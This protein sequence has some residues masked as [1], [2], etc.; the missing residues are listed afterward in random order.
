MSNG[1]TPLFIAAQ[2]GHEDREKGVER[3]V[4]SEHG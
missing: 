4:V 3:A 2:E 1:A